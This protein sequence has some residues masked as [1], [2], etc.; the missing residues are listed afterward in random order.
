MFFYFN[1]LNFK[2][3]QMKHSRKRSQKSLY[4]KPS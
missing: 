1:T 3:N 4:M 2:S